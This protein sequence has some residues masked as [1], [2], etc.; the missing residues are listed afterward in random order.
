L[1]EPTVD[2]FVTPSEFLKKKLVQYGYADNKIVVIPNFV[3]MENNITSKSNG[4]DYA[5]YFGR[6]SP[7]KGV[8][9]LLDAAKFIPHIEIAIVGDGPLRTRVLAQIEQQ[10]LKNVHYAGYLSGRDLWSFISGAKFTIVPSESYETFPY[11][12]IEALYLGK[13][14]IASRIGGLPEIVE[15]GING[16]LFNPGDAI[17]LSQKVSRLWD[18]PD[19]M[20]EFSLNAERKAKALY[21]PQRFYEQLSSVFERL[22]VKEC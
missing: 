5:V 18:K 10:E 1:I 7:E 16:L 12:A 8:M 4:K 17:D 15:D 2:L 6:L 13:P 19:L 9:T 20:K 3:A 21:T 22:G 11:S 14:V